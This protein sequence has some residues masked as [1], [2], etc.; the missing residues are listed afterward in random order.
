MMESADVEQ[1]QALIEEYGLPEVVHALSV[2]SYDKAT[3]LADSKVWAETLA[4]KAWRKAGAR[5]LM[6]AA[7]VQDLRDAPREPKGTVK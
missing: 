3:R 5:L 7:S 2:L 6:A 1:L 4:S